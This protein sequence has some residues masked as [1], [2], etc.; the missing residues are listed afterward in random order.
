M[1]LSFTPSGLRRGWN[2][3]RASQPNGD[4]CTRRFQGFVRR[5]PSRFCTSIVQELIH[6]FG[7]FIT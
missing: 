7:V 1:A 4:D 5:F 6:F 2:L 3:W